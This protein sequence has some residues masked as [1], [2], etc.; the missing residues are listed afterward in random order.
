MKV[1][2]RPLR[3]RI[4]VRRLEEEKKTLGGIIIPDTA[5]EKPQAGEV[6]AIG[7]GKVLDDGKVVPI[8]VKAGDRVMF[9]KYAGSEIK[10]DGEE[11]LILKEEDI[12]G[13][14]GK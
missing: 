9:G 8:E 7:Q 11:F 10:I 2:I 4:L 6:V 12:L 5:T 3:D 1:K 14:V 13:V